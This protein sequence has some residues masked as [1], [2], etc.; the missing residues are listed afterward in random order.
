VINLA[1]EAA[2]TRCGGL[3]LKSGIRGIATV[4]E[5]DTDVYGYII[6]GDIATELKIIQGGPG[7]QYALSGTYES[8]TFAYPNTNAPQAITLNNITANITK[9]ANTDIR[10]QIATANPVSG[11]CTGVSFT[12]VG[13]DGTAGT[14]FTSANGTDIIASLPYTTSGGIQNPTYCFRYKAFLSTTDRDATPQLLDFSLNYS[15]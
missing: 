11:S 2:P 12:Y 1:N 6:T 4:Q 8:T 15:R 7:G 9:P 5:A 3:Q 14:Y 13:P 10:L